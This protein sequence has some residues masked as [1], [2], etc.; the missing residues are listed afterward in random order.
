MDDALAGKVALVT[1]GASGIGAACAHTLAARGTRVMIADIDAAKAHRQAA[2]IVAAGG[3]ASATTVDVADPASV[4]AMVEHT[5]DVFGQLNLAVNNAGVAPEP[6][7]LHRIAVDDWR[8]MI[9][10]NLSGLFYSMRHEIP[11]MLAGNGG[12]IVNMASVL[13]TV[14][15]RHTAGYVAAKHGV[16]GLTKAAAL[17]YASSGIRVNAVC[18]G[19]V[20][21]P[22]LHED[23]SWELLEKYLTAL[24][25]VGRL[26]TEAEVAELAVFLL[27]ERA[28]F[29][30]GG[31]YL[32]DGGYAAQ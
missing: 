9:D 2:A 12:A 14:G 7:P 1:G 4:E 28:A 3:M 32:V 6:T 16:I 22:L 15:G 25:P 13:G 24:H 18:P 26:G 31:S 10:V 19:Y 21:S 23:G 27:S 8:R 17:D 30:T 11:V 20:D 5:R 29:I